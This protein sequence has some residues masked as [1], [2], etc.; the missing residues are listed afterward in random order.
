MCWL[1]LGNVHQDAAL[2]RALRW[3]VLSGLAGIRV[4]ICQQKAIV[5]NHRNIEIMELQAGGIVAEV[6]QTLTHSL[7]RLGAWNAVQQ[8][9]GACGRGESRPENQSKILHIIRMRKLCPAV[10]FWVALNHCF[11]SVLS[12]NVASLSSG[13]PM[14]VV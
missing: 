12:K 11:K 8:G 14:S 2:A 10:A 13:P 6:H 7:A 3:R 4:W 1:D 5:Q 9:G